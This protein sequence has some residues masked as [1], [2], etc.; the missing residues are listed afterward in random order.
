MPAKTPVPC[1]DH[2]RRSLMV[3]KRAA[4]KLLGYALVASG[5]G[6]A[7][8]GFVG[9]LATMALVTSLV[10]LAIATLLNERATAPH[11]TWIDE[12]VWF[13]LLAL[14]LQRFS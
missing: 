9:P 11:Y 6:L 3:L 2:G 13:F 8:H 12:A 14:I 5:Q 4:L 1:E 10:C 7:G